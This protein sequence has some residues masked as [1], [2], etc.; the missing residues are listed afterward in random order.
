VRGWAREP[1]EDLRV[2]ILVDG[3]E[4]RPR[5]FRRVPRPDVPRV[6]PDLGDCRWAGYEAIVERPAGTK[7][8]PVI[9]VVFRSRDGR[10]RHYPGVRIRWSD[11]APV[12]PR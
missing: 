11:A 10:S 8:E 3:A 4:V 7:P 12:A 1:G 5:E 9:S 6:F 2:S